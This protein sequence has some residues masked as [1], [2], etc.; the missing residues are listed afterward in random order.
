MCV[1]PIHQ[2]AAAGSSGIGAP[3]MKR[4]L[5]V[6]DDEENLREF[7]RLELEEEGYR[8]ETAANA[9][10]VLK[11]LEARKYDAIILDIQMPGMPGIDLLQKIITRDR[12]QPVILN[13][14][15]AFYQDNYLAWQ[16]DA[17]VV[18][19]SDTGELKQAI[20]RVLTGQR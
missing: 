1:A 10:E 17:Y 13:T 4:R 18:K 11:K 3:L 5:L 15:Y 19:S 7:Y 2:A 8:V 16:A 6:A 14:S 20:R 12:Q 9:V